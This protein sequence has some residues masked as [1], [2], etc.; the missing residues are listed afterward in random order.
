VDGWLPPFEPEDFLDPENPRAYNQLVMPDVYL[1]MRYKLQLAHDRAKGIVNEVGTQ[2]GETFGRSYGA[3]EAIDCEDAEI[4]LVSSSSTTSPSR[5][6]VRE[7]REKGVKIGLLKMRLFRPF[8]TEDVAKALIGAKKAVVIDRNCSFGK[9]GI[10][11]DEIRGALANVPNRPDI[12]GYI[13]GLG[14]RDIT[15][16][17]IHEVV[18]EVR[19][20]GP[21]Q[22]LAIWKG[23]KP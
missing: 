22:E 21:P 23:L 14:G 2:F 3:V 17:L 13:M 18:D 6:V 4:V 7:L 11:A 1:E 9:G 12:Y 16:A 20:S 19:Q 5:L 15:P 8:P 10:F